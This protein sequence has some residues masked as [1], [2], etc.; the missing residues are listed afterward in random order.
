MQLTKEWVSVDEPFQFH[1][2][3]SREVLEALEFGA[4]FDPLSPMEDFA[5]VPFLRG[6]E[7]ILMFSSLQ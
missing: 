6:T 2:L 7:H 1:H 3:P 5:I 4:I